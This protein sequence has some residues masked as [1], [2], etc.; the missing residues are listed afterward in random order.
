MA[1]TLAARAA[2]PIRV[3]VTDDSAFMRT[4]MTCMLESDPSMEVVG[5]ARDG[6]ETL[7]K[8]AAAATHHE[9]SFLSAQGS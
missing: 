2:A 8:A 6:L 5:T 4:A 9:S 7:E 3:L 1:M